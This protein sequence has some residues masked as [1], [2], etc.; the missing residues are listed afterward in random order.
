MQSP[1]KDFVLFSKGSWKALMF[2]KRE[3][4]RRKESGPE[5]SDMIYLVF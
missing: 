5:S 2:P 3:T 4:E 1:I